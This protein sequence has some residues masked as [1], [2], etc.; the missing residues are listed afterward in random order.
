MPENDRNNFFT[1]KQTRNKAPSNIF[2]RLDVGTKVRF[3]F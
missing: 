3:V 2:R 1:R